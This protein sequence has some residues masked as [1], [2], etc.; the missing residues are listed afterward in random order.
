MTGKVHSSP[1]LRVSAYDR[2]AGLLIAG[3]LLGT[4]VVATM[5][6]VW[7]SN[8]TWLPA[9]PVAVNIVPK[10]VGGD[11]GTETASSRAGDDFETPNSDE[12]P[13]GEKLDTSLDSLVSTIS[14]PDVAA[15]LTTGE[16]GDATGN[17]PGHSGKRRGPKGIGSED[18]VVTWERWEIRL[19]A[20]TLAEYARQLD[21]FEIELGVAGGGNPAVTY[22]SHF[23]QS[24]PQIR[25]GSP[26]AEQRLRFMHRSGELRDAD[27]QLVHKAGVDPAGK[28][29]FQFYSAAL[30][31]QLLK[32][33]H[34]A[35]GER[36]IREVRLTAFGVKPVGDKYE[37]FVSDQ[38]YR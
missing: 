34:V 10:E 36:P 14:T 35:K 32:L 22:V 6:V 17:G 12:T 1:A 5:L 30:H 29:V 28:V 26:Q 23:T 2:V 15:Q 21:F 27:R 11:G 18:G 38:E 16:L 13:P 9:A 3:L 4:F 7:L 20:E 33:E 37:F 19:N 25:T 31:A 8:R 24:Q